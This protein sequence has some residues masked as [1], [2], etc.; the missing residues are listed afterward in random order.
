M[1]NCPMLLGLILLELRLYPHLIDFAPLAPFRVEWLGVGGHYVLI[2]I[3]AS[4][5]IPCCG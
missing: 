2:G 3:L 5:L 4:L 1:P